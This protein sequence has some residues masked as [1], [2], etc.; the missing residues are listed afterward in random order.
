MPGIVFV[1]MLFGLRFVAVAIPAVAFFLW[2]PG[3]FRGEATVP[4]RSYVLIAVATLADAAWFVGGW[5]D[6]LRFQGVAYTHAV[7]AINVV[8]VTL[9]WLGFAV[10]S[11]ARK[12]F[13]RSLLLHWLL[14]AWLAW[15]AFPFFG[16]ML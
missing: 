9:L 7:F 10:S 2:N 6:G 3:L 4:K 13:N 16:E 12:S 11:K 5:K 14:F 15:S 1:G 8:W